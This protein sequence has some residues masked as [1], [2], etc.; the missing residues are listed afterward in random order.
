MK[1]IGSFNLMCRGKGI[2]YLVC[3]NVDLP[4]RR[5]EGHSCLW[6]S[7]DRGAG[8]RMLLEQL[9]V[10]VVTLQGALADITEKLHYPQHTHEF[11]TNN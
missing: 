3:V 11:S 1:Q 10:H 2:I 8:S 9:C 7:R 5:D 4:H 6:L